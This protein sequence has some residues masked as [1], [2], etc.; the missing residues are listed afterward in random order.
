MQHAANPRVILLRVDSPHTPPLHARRATIHN[1]VFTKTPHP[2]GIHGVVV[3]LVALGADPD[4]PVRPGLVSGHPNRVDFA[5]PRIGGHEIVSRGLLPR[6]RAFLGRDF[7]LTRHSP[8]PQS[9]P[10]RERDS[11]PRQ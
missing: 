1:Q 3:R 10:R 2:A 9:R 4:P 5:C 11:R 7:G 6:P 8:A